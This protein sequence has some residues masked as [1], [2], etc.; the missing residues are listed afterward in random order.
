MGYVPPISTDFIYSKQHKLPNLKIPPKFMETSY[1]ND[2]LVNIINRGDLAKPNDRT[3][4]FLSKLLG[5]ISKGLQL[6]L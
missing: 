1:A 4:S 6:V 5:Q 2:Q 3:P